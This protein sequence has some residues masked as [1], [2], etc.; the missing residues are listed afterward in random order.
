VLN[1]WFNNPRLVA[2]AHIEKLLNITPV[3]HESLPELT[4]FVAV[5]GESVS[6]L[7]SLN[8]PDLG[9]FILFS[10]ASRVLLV[11][12]RKLFEVNNS[13]DNPSF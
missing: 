12:V 10:L 5:F 8:I 1:E 9:S 7:T 6:L 4:K 3:Q 2:T 11:G 13:D